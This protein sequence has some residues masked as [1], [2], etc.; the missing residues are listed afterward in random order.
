MKAIYH[1]HLR[2]QKTNRK[3]NE[4]ISYHEVTDEWADQVAGPPPSQ[5]SPYPMPDEE[6]EVIDGEKRDDLGV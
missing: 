2:H 1:H 6:L 4:D 3:K 5:S